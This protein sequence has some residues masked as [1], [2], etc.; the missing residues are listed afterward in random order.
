MLRLQIFGEI[1]RSTKQYRDEAAKIA[2]SETAIRGSGTEQVNAALDNRA[3]TAEANFRQAIQN[4]EAVENAVYQNLGS[5]AEGINYNRLNGVPLNL[6][7]DIVRTSQEV[8][9]A[10]DVYL[11][12]H[13]EAAGQPRT[14]GAYRGRWFRKI[15]PGIAGT[16][17]NRFAR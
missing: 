1:R 11:E 9:K 10:R 2:R 4:A 17:C 3:I 5:P 15:R 7:A 16:S 14:A 6:H 12:T 8:L 13:P